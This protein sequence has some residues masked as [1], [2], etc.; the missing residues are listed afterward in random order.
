MRRRE[1]IAGL[2]STAMAR[3]LVARAQ[4]LKMPLVG[5]L[6][7]VSFEGPYEATGQHRPSR[8]SRFRRD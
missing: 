2:G 3:P 1:F 7:G 4:Q 6:N 8:R 5:L